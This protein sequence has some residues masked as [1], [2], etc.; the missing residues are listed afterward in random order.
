MRVRANSSPYDKFTP[1]QLVMGDK[2]EGLGFVWDRVKYPTPAWGLHLNV[3][4]LNKPLFGISIEIWQRELRLWSVDCAERVLPVWENWAKTNARGDLAAPRNAINAARKFAYGEINEEE[5]QICS[6][7][8]YN[9]SG[10]AYHADADHVRREYYAAVSAAA[11]S[12]HY[13]YADYAARNASNATSNYGIEG[14]WQRA[15]L[16][17]RLDAIAPW[18]LS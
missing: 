13:I 10:E 8:A 18:R 14:L 7:A 1:E 11:T 15:A 3:L 12:S 2:A 9:A 6:T 17:K 16:A 4:Q 5:L